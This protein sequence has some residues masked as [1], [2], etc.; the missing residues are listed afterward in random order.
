MKYIW[1][2]VTQWN[3]DCDYEAIMK[4]NN[5]RFIA[6]G[7]EH[8]PTTGR[9]HHQMFMY[10]RNR[11]S[12]STRNCN[13]MGD[14]FGT[15]HCKVEPMRGSIESNEYYCS[16]EN[17]LVKIGDEP[18]QGARHDLDETKEKIMKGDLT[19]DD[20]AVENPGMFHQYGRTLDRL[21]SISLRQRFR[22]EMTQGIW[23]TGPTGT[24]KSHTVFK[25]YDPDTH[26][27]KCLSDEWWDG[28]KGQET[29]IFNE[30]RGQ[31]PF[32]EMLDL[33]DKWPK[34]VKQRCKEPVPFLAKRLLIASIREP[35]DVYRNIDSGE[36]W[37]QFFR[38]CEV[39]TLEARGT[40]RKIGQ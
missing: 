18:K 14:W 4:K 34:T 25:G 7:L 31:I 19:A 37:E 30:F 1:F 8:A 21:E 35:K 32:S 10:M 40:K 33:M 26:Y 5:I 13:K 16:K 28:Y 17:E 15:T 11:V 12:G 6:Y 29:V 27:I 2:V 23:Y 38:R 24:G 9:A 22:T 3:V 36:P 39:V 20:V